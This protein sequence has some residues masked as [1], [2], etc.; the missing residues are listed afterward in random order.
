M[1]GPDAV[2]R[3]TG[4]RREPAA[5]APA[6]AGE[7]RRAPPNP[8]AGVPG[9]APHHRP[10]AGSADRRLARATAVSQGAAQ[11]W[12]MLWQEAAEGA[13]REG[14][15]PLSPAEVKALWADFAALRARPEPVPQDL[16]ARVTRALLETAG[17]QEEAQPQ[18][19]AEPVA[20]PTGEPDRAGAGGGTL[21]WAALAPDGSRRPRLVPLLRLLAAEA[22]CFPLS[23]LAL[24][25]L[26]MAGGLVLHLVAVETARGLWP[27]WTPAL[28]AAGDGAGALGPASPLALDGWR[29]I[30]L[31]ADS[32]ALVAPWLGTLV[33]LAAVWPRR[34]MLW[35]D[36]ETLSPFPAASR[37]LA[38]AG[39]AGLLATL[40]ILVTGWIQP[41]AVQAFMGLPPGGPAPDTVLAWSA[42]GAAAGVPGGS[43]GGTLGVILAR[44]A[45]LWLAAA[46]ALW[47]HM[48]AGTLGAMLASAG[49]WTAVT[50]GGHWLGPWNPLAAGPVP[51][52]AVQVAMLLLATLLGWGLAKQA[53]AGEVAA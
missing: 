50:L 46:W 29:L 24:Q 15:D 35:A 7:E 16:V 12:E 51:A 21:D 10:A 26:L 34:Q 41:A 9:G 53:G 11:A 37:L 8:A 39:V 31:S 45:P 23:F 30:L 32:L 5:S 19:G 6:P 52:V 14:D 2:G 1:T 25:L 33:A 42:A 48:R 40:F 43:P 47:W 22:R 44:L 38:R 17:G 28:R 49:L 36:L 4:E 18:E 13:R 27:D 20:V 3:R